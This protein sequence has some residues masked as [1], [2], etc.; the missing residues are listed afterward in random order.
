MRF[1]LGVVAAALLLGMS[2]QVL[3]FLAIKAIAD[4]AALVVERRAGA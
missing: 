3:L 2:T 4:V 1:L